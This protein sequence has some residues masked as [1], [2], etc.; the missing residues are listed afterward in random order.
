MTSSEP[1]GSEQMLHCEVSPLTFSGRPILILT[2][3]RSRVSTQLTSG[4]VGFGEG[5]VG[6]YGMMRCSNSAK[7]YEYGLIWILLNVLWLVPVSAHIEQAG[8][9][10]YGSFRKMKSHVACTSTVSFAS[11]YKIKSE[12]MSRVFVRAMVVSDVNA[13]SQNI[14]ISETRRKT[15]NSA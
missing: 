8:K 14:P 7:Q 2:N 9:G 12:T 1:K 10:I 15:Y 4:R 13:L 11:H 5:E 6:L 3:V